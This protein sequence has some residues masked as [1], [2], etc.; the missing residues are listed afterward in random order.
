[1][2]RKNQVIPRARLVIHEPFEVRLRRL[3][4]AELRNV[5]A[6]FD[7]DALRGHFVGLLIYIDGLIGERE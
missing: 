5:R 2:T 3:S 4:T 7:T 1:M 6:F